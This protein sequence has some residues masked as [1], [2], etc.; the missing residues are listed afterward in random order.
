MIRLLFFIIKYIYIYNITII[1]G[2]RFQ[3]LLKERLTGYKNFKIY[4]NFYIIFVVKRNARDGVY[5]QKRI[6]FSI[7]DDKN[8]K[9][10]KHSEQWCFF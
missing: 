9:I 6:L 7:F 2:G 4:K 3:E 5:M 1:K 8:Q 10:S